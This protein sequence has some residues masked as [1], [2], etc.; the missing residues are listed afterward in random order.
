MLQYHFEFL[1]GNTWESAN[2][3]IQMVHT[4]RQLYFRIDI[5][6]PPGQYIPLFFTAVM[7]ALRF[8]VTTNVAVLSSW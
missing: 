3:L 7:C 4:V 8:F 5:G 1:L 2:L 6:D